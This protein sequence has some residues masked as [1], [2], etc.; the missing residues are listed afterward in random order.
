M[1]ARPWKNE[2][3]C[4][5]RQRQNCARTLR[6][7]IS[8]SRFRDDAKN[9]SARTFPISAFDMAT[10]AIARVEGVEW[11]E[12]ESEPEGGKPRMRARKMIQKSRSHAA[13]ARHAN[14]LSCKHECSHAMPQ[15]HVAEAR[16][17]FPSKM[18]SRFEAMTAKEILRLLRFCC[19]TERFG[20]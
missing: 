8:S 9:P 3:K 4:G 11:F 16:C 15:P 6:R 5:D 19:F 7:A 1:G 18:W 20:L 2:S 13:S 14:T 10:A 17:V 12:K